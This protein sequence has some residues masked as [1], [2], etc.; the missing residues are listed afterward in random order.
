MLIAIHDNKT[1]FTPYWIKYCKTKGI[2][3]K[4]VNCYSSDIVDE[5]KECDALMWHFS[6]VNSKDFL[7]A[8]KLLSALEVSGKIVFPDFKTSWHFDDKYAQKYLFESLNIPAV[9]SYHFLDKKEAL[10]WA[11]QTEFPKVFKLKGGAGSSNV[12]LVKSKVEAKRLIKKAFSLG[13][14][15]YDRFEAIKERYRKFKNNKDSFLGVMKSF[16]RIFFLPKYAKTIG[17]QKY[18]IYF[19]DFIPNNNCDYRVIIIDEKAFAIKR[20]V[21]ENDFRASGSGMIQYDESLFAKELIESAFDYASKLDTQS[22]SF[23]FVESELGKF[24]VEISYGFVPE[25][26]EKCTGY[27]DKTLTFHKG[28]LDYCSWMVDLV[29]KKCNKS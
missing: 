14:L 21:R 6:Q 27:W 18:E 4:L 2:N 20:L 28:K 5:L 22:V 11:D 19:Q 15:A 13:F 8:K 24:I 9:K 10:D 16:V 25:I 3:F 1:G 12:R 7:K 17:R 23:D 29:V 26:Y